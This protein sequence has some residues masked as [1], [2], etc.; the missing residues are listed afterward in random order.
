[1]NLIVVALLFSLFL[2]LIFWVGL[3]P[4]I[5]RIKEKNY[6]PDEFPPVSVVICAKNEAE[7]LAKNLKVVLFQ[8]YPK[9]EVIVVDDGSVDA[10]AKV[11]EDYKSR[12]PHLK[13][14][15][16]D[17]QIPKSFLGKKSALICG[18][19]AAQYDHIAVTDADC[20]PFHAHWLK[21]GMARMMKD[22]EFVLGYS[23]FYIQP[24][25]LNIFARFE[26][27]LVAMHY[28]SLARIG[29]PYMGVGRNL[30]FKRTTFLN[31]NGFER[32]ANVQS[33]DDDLFVNALATKD[34]TEVVLQS[35]SFVYTE[36]KSTMKDW[37]NQ[38]IRHVNAG[39]YYKWQHLLCIHLF[40]MSQVL[41]WC[42]LPILF[43]IQ[44]TYQL[45]LASFFILVLIA[46]WFVLSKA[47]EKLEQSSLSKNIFWLDPLY[48]LYLIALF[49]L[50][51]LG[52]RPR[53]KEVQKA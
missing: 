7:N 12:N 8:L 18:V 38:K 45:Y 21:Q 33:G 22:T 9:F 50:I 28:F 52:I 47:E 1:M 53:W 39:L 17:S 43:F 20:R 40:N 14:V 24:N 42:L 46:K 16:R 15:Y 51:L 11:L 34:N 29:F 31:K 30:F 41:S 6:L 10:T 37:F 35:E 19:E 3:F 4:N 48:S 13:I 23:P 5:F 44:P 2:Q 36:A 49:L 26:N 27:V 25:A 32:H